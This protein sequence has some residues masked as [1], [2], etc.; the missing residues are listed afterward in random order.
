[1]TPGRYVGIAETETSQEE[2][3]TK[4][5]ALVADLNAQMAKGTELDAQIKDNLAKLGWG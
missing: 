1:M 2:F 3:E 4:M 5:A